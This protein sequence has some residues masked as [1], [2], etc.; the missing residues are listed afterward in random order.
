MK[1]RNKWTK[2]GLIL[3]SI[4]VPLIGII[5]WYQSLKKGEDKSAKIYICCAV[6]GFL[7]N[8]IPRVF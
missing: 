1:I 8:F 6:I 2:I 7:I 3:F 4:W 5:M